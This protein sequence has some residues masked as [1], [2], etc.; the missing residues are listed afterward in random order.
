MELGLNIL[1]VLEGEKQG[2]TAAEISTTLRESELFTY[3]A[4]RMLRDAGYVT[5]NRGMK[6]GYV[7]I[8][9]STE[10]T[11]AE[12]LKTFG[13]EHI[14]NITTQQTAA[15]RAQKLLAH[16]LASIRITDLFENKILAPP[17]FNPPGAA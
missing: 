10:R 2:I 14:E 11:L 4:L 5:A 12:Y 13:R 1:Q 15:A 8:P 9:G 6:G 17:H 7:L 3:Q 16:Y